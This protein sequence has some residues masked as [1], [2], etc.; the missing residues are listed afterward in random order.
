MIIT[1]K[2]NET[3]T[4]LEVNMTNR[5]G[6][7]YR[8]AFSRDILKDM[9]I[10]YKKLHKSPFEGIDMSGINIEGKSE[11]EIYQML[12]SKVDMTKLLDARENATLDFEETEMGGH[13]IWAFAKNADD[14]IKG[15]E[16]WIDSFE[17]ILPVGEIV[18]A[19]LEAWNNAAAPTVELKN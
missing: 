12:I 2:L 11:E 15:Y 17:Y 19:L 9:Q 10:I 5:V 6:R 16:D 4:E 18:S 3:N 8:Q 7:I 14:K 13:I 1:L